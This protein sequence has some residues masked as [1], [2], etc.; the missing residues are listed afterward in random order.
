MSRKTVNPVI[1]LLFLFSGFTGLVYEILW[2]RMFSLVFGGTTLSI[3]LVLASYMAGM[4]LGSL[5]FGRFV[6]KRNDPLRIYAIIEI[7]IGLYAVILP[8]LILLLQKFYISSSSEII[9]SILKARYIKFILSFILLIIPT[10]LMGGTLPVLSR[11]LVNSRDKIGL[12]VGRLYSVNTLGGAAGCFITGFILISSLGIRVTVYMASAINIV[13]GG[14]ALWLYRKKPLPIPIS[15]I[16][17]TEVKNQI[18]PR[19][20]KFILIAFG[21]SGFIA[22]AYEVIW[23]RILAMILGTSV[24]AFSIMLTAFLCG[25]ALGG[26]IFSKLV[27]RIKDLVSV[28]GLVEI[29]IGFFAVVSIAAFKVAPVIFLWLFD[30]LGG[31]WGMASLVQMMIALIIMLIPASLM[32]AAFP[33]VSRICTS[34]IK[35]LGRSVGGAYSANTFGAI[36]GTLVSAFLMIP[37]IGLKNSIALLAFINICIGLISVVISWLSDTIRPG[38]KIIA[39]IS[40][41]VLVLVIL[42]LVPS[43]DKRV[44]S[45]GVYFDPYQYFN[46]ADKLDVE[47]RTNE[48]QMVYYADG[49]DS[50]VAVFKRGINITLKINGK[51]V[52]STLRTDLNLLGMMGHLPAILH[53]KPENALVIGLG[54]GVTSGMLA[55]HDTIKQ[56]DCVELEKKVTEAASYFAKENHN[57][58][59]NPRLNLII[60]DGRNYLL[61]T[62]KKYDVITSDPIHPWVSGA[63]S[64]YAI[65]HFN[66]CREHLKPHGVMA[67]WLPLYEMPEKDFKMVIKTFQSVF[68]HTTLWITSSDTILI[69]TQE[70][71]KIDYKA[72]ENKLK[73]D[74]IVQDM[75]MLF[76]DS[77]YD[78][79]SSFVM[80]EDELRSYTENARINT[81]N[82]PILE[83]S[84]PKGLYSQTVDDNLEAI[85]QRMN[86]VFP[87]LYNINNPEEVKE[88]LESY[89]QTK[90]EI[91][92]EQIKNLS[93]FQKTYSL[94]K[95]AWEY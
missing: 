74:K 68:P 31:T 24:Y 9:T 49:I 69:G 20:Q 33:L 77:I 75:R 87:L 38:L 35:L 18:S 51:P 83:F 60:D 2:T 89:F 27:D 64:L 61:T 47:R 16:E 7:I 14:M 21:I 78:F 40:V 25:I 94:Y 90:K 76:I 13:V 15:R 17:K 53:G 65:E 29:F 44:L 93:N 34:D 36:G 4:A 62:N 30:R 12:N 79:L 1:Y 50:T 45:G 19:V 28:F 3:S 48:S 66:L 59:E 70:K 67:Q 8:L 72:L 91:I 55:R 43:W 6:D 71:L 52:A 37:L 42:I 81:D 58:L 10:T 46:R 92:K 22:L 23:T 26:Y 85:V 88:K 39:A 73:D 11:Q 57:I 32:G 5:Y 41:S 54:A 86:R 80:G 84:A 82:H 95:T 56:V 63:G